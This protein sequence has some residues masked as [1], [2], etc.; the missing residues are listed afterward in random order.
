MPINT[1]T[2]NYIIAGVLALIA[3]IAIALYIHAHPLNSSS[4]GQAATSTPIT[5]TTNGVTVSGG[6]ATVTEQSPALVAPDYKK[7][8]TF[9]AD[10]SA[11]VRAVFQHQFDLTIQALDKDK[12]SFA[13]WVNLST[14]RKGT[15]DYKGS[16]TILI[17][18][19]KLYPKST[20]PTDNLGSLYLDFIKDYPKAESNFK[21]SIGNDPHDINAYEQ[22]TSLYTTY[23]YKDKATA[24][25]LLQQG[26]AANPGNQTLLDLQTQLGTQ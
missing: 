14:L 8:L 10:V 25:A 18:V 3:V 13:A 5:T 11:D 2:R 9:Q 26:L 24:R 16:E 7:P 23:G 12:S 20:V 1:Q 15:G 19:S 4:S 17:Y 6:N 21:A 22:L